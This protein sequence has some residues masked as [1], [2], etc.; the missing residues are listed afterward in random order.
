[1]TPLRLVIALL[2]NEPRLEPRF[3]L[4]D[5]LVQ[6]EAPGMPLLR[7]LL[8]YIRSIEEPTAGVLMH[9]LES[10]AELP[11]LVRL[12]NWQP[13]VKLDRAQLEELFD[14][15]VH[16]LQRDLYRRGSESLLALAE[17]RELT[18]AEKQKLNEIIKKS[19]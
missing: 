1:M 3:S 18:D 9:R 10:H 7:S 6:S 16:S 2:L 13:A 8:Q 5:E 14:D 4:P 15:A 11:V 17:Q 12:A 19:K